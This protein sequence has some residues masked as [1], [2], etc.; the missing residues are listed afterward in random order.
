MDADE[1]R[2]SLCKRLNCDDDPMHI[3]TNYGEVPLTSEDIIA[4]RKL[5]RKRFENRL[6]KLEG[7][8]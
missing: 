3:H 7:K 2:Y 1:I 4:V 6:R 8:S 5:L